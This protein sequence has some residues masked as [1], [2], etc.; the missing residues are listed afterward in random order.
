MVTIFMKSMN[1]SYYW[2]IVA[3]LLL[4]S[5]S[6]QP[7]DYAVRRSRNSMLPCY[8]RKHFDGRETVKIKHIY[9]DIWV[10]LFAHKVIFE[11]LI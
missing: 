5:E 8:Y 2:R 11:S 7:K 10:S 6:L 3:I 1:H 9:G 4:F